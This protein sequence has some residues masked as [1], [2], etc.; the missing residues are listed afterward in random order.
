LDAS[1]RQN[2]LL[3]VLDSVRTPQVEDR[4][5]PVQALARGCTRIDL[6]SGD[7]NNSLPYKD[8]TQKKGPSASA[9]I[10][11]ALLNAAGRRPA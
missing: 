11:R 3:L 1:G 9:M 8:G 4:T 6:S 7:D 10:G 2:G 5:N